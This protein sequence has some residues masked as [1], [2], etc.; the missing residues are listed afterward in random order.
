MNKT[1]QRFL[2]EAYRL[3]SR[4]ATIRRERA[5]WVTACQ[6]VPRHTPRV[7][8]GMDHI[9]T[10][11][12]ALS[13][14]LVKCQDL[15]TLFPNT[16]R[17]PNLLYLVSSALPLHADIMVR[18][19]HEVGAKVVLNQNGVAYPAWHGRGW[20]K[21]NVPLAR[22]HSQADYIF[23]QSRFCQLG[24]E[25]FL[26]TR[27]CNAE[28][29]YNPVDT[30]R[31]V[32]PISPTSH[33]KPLI[34]V[35]GSHHFSYRISLAVDTLQLVL[36]N[37]PG[38]SLQISGSCCWRSSDAE[39]RA[40][41]MAYAK[42]LNISDHLR[43]TGAYTQDEAPSVFQQ[44]HVL[45]HTQVNDACPRLVVE[46]MSCGVPV[47]CSATGGTAEL[48]GDEGGI[49][50]PGPL[51]WNQESPPKPAQL[52]D[53]INQILETHSRYSQSARRRAL[54]QFALPPWLRRHTSVLE[55]LLS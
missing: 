8:Y 16:T 36:K 37:H 10:R 53:A 14:G 34:L 25:T 39:C 20:E 4:P 50:I 48:I 33:A 21:A 43:F 30:D 38:A 17:A 51:D 19:A 27:A 26:G 54:L 23:Y 2:N 7:Y 31:F 12:E 35:A 11:S 29:L 44:A 3:Y 52:A 55:G 15:Q 1:V 32:P 18:F 13:G 45:L 6:D 42:S 9:P 47:V 41:T 5:R 46:A 22:I 24:A 28:V 40:E 49:G